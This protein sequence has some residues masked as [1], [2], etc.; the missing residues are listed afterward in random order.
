MQNNDADRIWELIAGKLSCE[1]TADELE[2]LGNLL[3]K[4]PAQAYSLEIME[5]LWSS[6]IPVNRQY[7][8][9]KYKELL[10]RMQKMDLITGDSGEEKEHL[11]RLM[12]EDK[13]T[14]GKVTGISK[15]VKLLVAASV[16]VII[17]LVVLRHS[18]NSKM[19]TSIASN[20]STK[21]E[22]VTKN[23]TKTNL[24]LPDGTK[25]WLNAGSKLSYDETYGNKYREVVLTGEG[26][27]DV[28][29]NANKPFI[30][31]TRKMDIKVL[32][33]AFNVRCYPDEKKVET[34][35][36]RGS[37][38]VTLKDRPTEKIYLKPNEK[39]TLIDEPV[40]VNSMKNE[41]RKIAHETAVPE[42]MVAI[43]H[44]TYNT[45]DNSVM[46][47]SWLQNK[48]V[49]K[50]ETFEAVAKKMEK[51][52]N[53]SIVFSDQSVKDLHFTG[54]FEKETV[55]EALSAMQITTPFHFSINKK[56]LITISK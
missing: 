12:N 43:S 53:V 36:L 55:S 9:Y 35:L 34:S 14:K 5:D 16:I 10:L 17:S 13:K 42:P 18:E 4:L 46:E 44:L 20:I 6:P 11:V 41:G 38:E 48:L 2:E 24:V 45:L 49:F 56:E 51:W 28:T 26:F 37:I 47:T 30:I 27:F 22:I 3:K 23:A 7:S 15:T 21:K 52:Y 39:L 32:G 33:T 19:N 50:S 1:A 29:K 8:E 40:A 54:I 25:V 31:H